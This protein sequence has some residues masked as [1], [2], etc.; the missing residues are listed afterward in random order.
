MKTAPLHVAEL[1]DLPVTISRSARD[2]SALRRL[3]YDMVALVFQVDPEQLAMATRGPR[4]IAHARQVA[5]YLAHIVGGLSLTEVG[6]LFERDRTTVAH[7]CALI[8]DARDEQGFDRMLEH[9]ERAVSQQINLIRFSGRV[10]ATKTSPFAI[11]EAA[12]EQ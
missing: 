6:R 4:P 11:R 10:Y 7:A 2:Q 9:L 12:N 3:I 1:A 5:M 8:E